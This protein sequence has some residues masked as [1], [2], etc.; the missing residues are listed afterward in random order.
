MEGVREHDISLFLSVDMN[1]VS[2][3]APRPS[4]DHVFFFF[5]IILSTHSSVTR[6]PRGMAP[7]NQYIIY[8]CAVHETPS[9]RRHIVADQGPFC[10]G[11]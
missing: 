7:R 11:T 4:R 3:A 9:G 5:I 1:F 6:L 10:R 8:Y 2:L